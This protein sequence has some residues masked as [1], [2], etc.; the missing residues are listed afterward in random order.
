[1]YEFQELKKCIYSPLLIILKNYSHFGQAPPPLREQIPFPIKS[2]VV[3]GVC[4]FFLM[5]SPC[6]FGSKMCI[7]LCTVTRLQLSVDPA[8]TPTC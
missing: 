1:M 8:V 6:S 2:L 4:F 7:L 3:F 5:F